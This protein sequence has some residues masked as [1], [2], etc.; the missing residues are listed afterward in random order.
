MDGW[1]IKVAEQG[2]PGGLVAAMATRD[3][4][5]WISASCQLDDVPVALAEVLSL[6]RRS[7][8]LPRQDQRQRQRQ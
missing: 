6:A 4:V 1:K 3:R 8:V 7:G 2:L 5:I